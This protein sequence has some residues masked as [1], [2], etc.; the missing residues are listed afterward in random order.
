[1]QTLLKPEMLSEEVKK[2]LDTIITTTAIAVINVKANPNDDASESGNLPVNAN[3]DPELQPPDILKSVR[4]ANKVSPLLDKFRK[5]TSKPDNTY[6]LRNNYLF[7]ED[8]L[9]IP[10][11]GRLHVKL[12]D[13]IHR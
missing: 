6:N 10:D 2:D 11:E 5:Q 1:M 7:F 4:K 12:I 9:I 13:H 3:S 8:R